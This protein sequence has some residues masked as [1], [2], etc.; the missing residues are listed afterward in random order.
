[1]SDT[2]KVITEGVGVRG[3]F[4][5]HMHKQGCVSLLSSVKWC[6]CASVSTC[7]CVCI[8]GGV[9]VSVI[10]MCMPV[11]VHVKTCM[12]LCVHTCIIYVTNCQITFY[13]YPPIT[14]DTNINKN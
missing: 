5:V 10:D 12:Q 6:V 11:C 3:V 13:Q 1:M 4:C 7:V 8:C 9:Y 14:T 2:S